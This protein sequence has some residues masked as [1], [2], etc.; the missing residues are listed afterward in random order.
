MTIER[1]PR[2]LREADTPTLGRSCLGF[3]F[4][5][6]DS[7]SL[8]ARLLDKDIGGHWSI[9][10]ITDQSH[11]KQQYL[12]NSAI[13]STKFLSDE[14]VCTVNDFM[15]R[16]SPTA[17]GDKPLLPWVVR[18]VEVIRGALDFRMECFPAFDYARAEHTTE[19]VDD[20]KCAKTRGGQSRKKAVFRSKLMTMEL[21]AISGCN[22]DVGTCSIDDLPELKFVT[23]TSAWPR[24]KGPGVVCEFHLKEGETA[25][26]ILRQDPE[27][28]EDVQAVP[29]TKAS[30]PDKA[31]VVDK[32]GSW[33]KTRRFDLARYDP[34]LDSRLVQTLQDSVSE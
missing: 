11:S 33:I 32:D 12:P 10:P 31:P 7:P 19:I 17:K 13:I 23:D 29:D 3:C 5:Y 20:E 26:F 34:L 15:P 6:F 25:D 9:Q 14:G 27:E 28:A 4:P 24:H 1:R 22:P 2:D 21:R 8:F 16:P 18:R 30:N